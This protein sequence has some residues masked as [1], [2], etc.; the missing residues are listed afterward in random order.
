MAICSKCRKRL[1]FWIFL[2][3]FNIGSE[4]LLDLELLITIGVYQKVE[5]LFIQMFITLTQC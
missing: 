3:I 2:T 4:L 5:F 1:I